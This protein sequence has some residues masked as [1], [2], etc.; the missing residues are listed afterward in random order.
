MVK[1]S[2]GIRGVLRSATIA[3]GLLSAAGCTLNDRLLESV[4]DPVCGKMVEKS[5]APVEREFLRKTYYFD[6]EACAHTFDVHP[7]RYCDVASTMY[8]EYDY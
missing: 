4:H 8:P 7:A 1:L 2:D 5:K 3:A 6:S